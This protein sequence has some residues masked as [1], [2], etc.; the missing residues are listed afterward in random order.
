MVRIVFVQKKRESTVEYDPHLCH[1]ACCNRKRRFRNK[2]WHISIVWCFDDGLN[3][4]MANR[5]TI[6]NS[7]FLS[8]VGT[9]RPIDVQAVKW[10]DML[11]FLWIFQFFFCWIF[12]PD[13]S[14]KKL[15]LSIKFRNETCFGIEFMRNHF[16][17]EKKLSKDFQ[18]NLDNFFDGI[19]QQVQ[20]WASK[21]MMRRWANCSLESMKIFKFWK[22]WKV[23]KG[24]KEKKKKRKK[25]GK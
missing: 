22:K 7:S 1:T 25:I 16:F 19:F 20:I 13:I 5:S 12:T 18:K 23:K 21:Y 10:L 9:K 6:A 2:Y 15:N 24:W 4:K 8:L 11:Q 17:C 14:G 3:W